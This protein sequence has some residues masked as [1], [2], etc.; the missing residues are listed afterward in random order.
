MSEQSSADCVSRDEPACVPHDPPLTG[1]VW[2]LRHAVALVLGVA[3][4][5]VIASRVL[6]AMPDSG[7][8]ATQRSLFILGTFLSVYALEL[9][10]VWLV[11]RRFGVPFGESI[12]LRSVPRMGMWLAL[13]AA[14]SVGLRIAATTYAGIM[15]Q[16]HWLLPGWD[17]NPA[18]FFPRTTLGSAVLVFI[19]VLAAPLVEE[20]IFRGVLLGSLVAR[21]GEG[22]GVGLTVVVFAVMHLN[23][24][25]F[26]PILLV[27][28]ALATLFLRSRSL[29]VSVAC[30]S[31]FNGIGV[32][33]LL[34]L[35]GNG[36][37]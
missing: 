35:R 7:L 30:H 4:L 36:I 19:I 20:V 22:W 13:A 12:G 18:R 37:V 26:A 32:V 16:M 3:G 28:W 8:D 2:R 29:W 10:V 17:A 21:F 11:A 23:P 6:R 33:A 27:G 34:F 25:S 24:F 31:A 9:G 14:T 15:L 5:T 1:L